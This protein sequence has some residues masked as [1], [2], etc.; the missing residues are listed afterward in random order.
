MDSV[1]NLILVSVDHID[2]RVLRKKGADHRNRVLRQLSVV[3]TGDENVRLVFPG[4]DK[5]FQVRIA[6]HFHRH[7]L[8]GFFSPASFFSQFCHQ[9]LLMTQK[10]FVICF[11]LHGM[12]LLIKMLLIK[13]KMFLI[14]NKMPQIILKMPQITI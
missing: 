12:L 7:G 2:I 10:P 14:K 9:L 5:V 1:R 13:I 4:Q 6:H 8:I 11:C 3:V